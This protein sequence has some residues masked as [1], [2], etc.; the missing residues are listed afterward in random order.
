MTR[1]IRHRLNFLGAIEG[2]EEKDTEIVVAIDIG[3]FEQAKL[4][5]LQYSSASE[6]NESS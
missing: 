3:S 4:L 1:R 5:I 2:T 6:K